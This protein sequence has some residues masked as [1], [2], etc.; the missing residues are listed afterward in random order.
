MKVK[1]QALRRKDTPK[2][3][4]CFSRESRESKAWASHRRVVVNCLTIIHR[5]RLG[6]SELS[7]QGWL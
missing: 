1:R 2:G 5:D 6:D 4:I 7:F 3:I